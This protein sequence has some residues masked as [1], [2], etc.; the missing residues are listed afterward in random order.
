MLGARGEAYREP[1][2]LAGAPGTEPHFLLLE[3][4]RKVVM[5]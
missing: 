2:N 1:V 3:I 5:V 4:W